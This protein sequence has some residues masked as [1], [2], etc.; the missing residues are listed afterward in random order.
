LKVKLY[1][2]NLLYKPP[3]HPVFGT[4]VIVGNIGVSS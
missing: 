4:L 1:W 2:I 3:L